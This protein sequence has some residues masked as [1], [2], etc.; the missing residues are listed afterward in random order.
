MYWAAGQVDGDGCIGI[1]RRIPRIQLDKAEKGLSSIQKFVDL[2][3][4][5]V[6]NLG[7]RREGRQCSY[8]WTLQGK[9]AA[10][11]IQQ[12]QP[13]LRIKAQQAELIGQLQLGRNPMTM[14]RDNQVWYASTRKE[15]STRLGCCTALVSKLFRSGGEPDS[16]TY[17]GYT[18][19][20]GRTQNNDVERLIRECQKSQHPEI[21]ETLHPA[22]VAGF[23]DA[24]GSL[25]FYKTGWYSLE[26]AQKYP[27]ILKALCSQYGGVIK[28]RK[29]CYRWHLHKDHGLKPFLAEILPYMIEKA[30]QA[31]LVMDSTTDT[32]KDTYDT[33][34]TLRGM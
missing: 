30:Q 31:N 33:M 7:I 26:V 5:K 11:A 3:G 6:A 13:Y 29:D 15:A 34:G 9:P 18:V 8:K 22:Y 10:N 20:R 25:K 16:F 1:Y 2:F 12:L 4:G 23:V 24:E 14:Q 28:E 19:T 17:M 27:A 21:R 32:H